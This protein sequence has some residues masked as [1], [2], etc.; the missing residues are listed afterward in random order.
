MG[1]L[2]E[3]VGNFLVE[4]DKDGFGGLLGGSNVSCRVVSCWGAEGG[5]VGRHDYGSLYWYYSNVVYDV[6]CTTI[7][8]LLLLL[9]LLLLPAASPMEGMRDGWI[10]CG[11]CLQA[12]KQA[13]KQA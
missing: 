10:R 7:V 3:R 13:S 11:I 8:L 4:S 6:L 1:V 12:S 5:G 2:N 9:L